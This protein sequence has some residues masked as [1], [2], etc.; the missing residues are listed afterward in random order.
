MAY[1]R[2]AEKQ[3]LLDEANQKLYRVNAQM[4]REALAMQTEL[5]AIASRYNRDKRALEQSTQ[6]IQSKLVPLQKEIDALQREQTKLQQRL[7]ELQDDQTTIQR[8]YNEQQTLLQNDMTKLAGLQRDQVEAEKRARDS[9][10]REIER[11]KSEVAQI[12]RGIGTLQADVARELANQA[13]ANQANSNSTSGTAG[14]QIGNL[15]K[16]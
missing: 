5:D 12:T 13:R 1:D 14:R 3:R 11:L 7:K 4:Q 6:V 15:R 10:T 9:K 2:V 16:W 8:R